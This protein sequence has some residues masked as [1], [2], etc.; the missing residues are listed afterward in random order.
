MNQLSPN[1]KLE[2]LKDHLRLASELEQQLMCAYLFTAFSIKQ[3]C[4]DEDSMIAQDRNKQ[5]KSWRGAV[6]GV[7]VQEMLHLGLVSNMLTAIGGE[8]YFARQ[9]FPLDYEDMKRFGY[10]DEHKAKLGLWKFSV[11]SIKRFKWFESYDGGA[12]PVCPEQEDTFPLTKLKPAG[13]LSLEK[14][15]LS[16]LVELYENIARLF[17]ELAEE[18]NFQLFKEPGALVSSQITDNQVTALFNYPPALS[19]PR[20]EEA[21]DQYTLPLLNAVTDLKSALVA[22]DTI[23]VQGEGDFEEWRAFL[24]K[25]V[26]KEDYPGFWPFPTIQSPSH[27]DTFDSVLKGLEGID[28]EPARDVVNNPLP[29]R[30]SNAV[31]NSVAELFNDVYCVM[32]DVLGASF[33]HQGS[34]YGVAS[35]TQGA[36]RMMVYV[37]SPLGNM[38]TQL[39][40][41]DKGERK[42]GPSFIYEQN[43]GH[44][45]KELENRLRDVAA[46]ASRIAAVIPREE[47]VYLTP[48]YL[49]IP[50]KGQVYPQTTKYDLLE[51]MVS[52]NLK[53]MAN[54]IQEVSGYAVPELHV[55]MGLNACKGQDITGAA[56]MAGVGQC[57]TADPHI[58]SGQNSCRDQGGCGFTPAPFPGM[59]GLQDH[60]GEND[61]KGL[62][63]CGS[64]I[65]PSITNTRDKNTDPSLGLDGDKKIYEK[66][67]GSVW[68][69][70]RILFEKKMK[71]QGKAYGP[72]VGP[73]GIGGHDFP[74]WSPKNGE[75]P[76]RKKYELE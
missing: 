54:R 70:A 65:L 3:D 61:C 12:F 55:C 27:E 28:W 53:F 19:Q 46:N 68:R 1:E 30:I 14:L 60:P 10:E 25:L 48:G 62:G 56:T 15:G 40:I 32:L 57:A 66:G 76:K 2:H 64:P 44:S 52:R 24:E 75:E 42:A 29:D 71:A 34:P 63:A 9:N 4:P 45:W 5:L 33:A 50:K 35:L 22:I 43:N 23:I 58:C 13:F 20:N 8:P 16:T 59:T 38:L 73:G 18:K 74:G 47:K 51:N 17:K 11:C 6:T 39:K 69:Y 41:D 21:G 37:M 31:T 49:G 26:P 67:Q 72:S 7:A 36:L